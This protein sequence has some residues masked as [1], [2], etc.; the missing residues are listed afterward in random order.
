MLPDGCFYYDSHLRWMLLFCQLSVMDAS[1]LS[2]VFD[3]YFYFLSV[4]CDGYFYFCQLSVMDGS[5][6]SVFCVLFFSVVC[7]GYFCF[8]QLS[9]MKIIFILGEPKVICLQG[10][11]LLIS[12]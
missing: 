3:G 9:V 6:L 8:C 5:I 2:V 11:R 4:I 10:I 12:K 7:D 1:I